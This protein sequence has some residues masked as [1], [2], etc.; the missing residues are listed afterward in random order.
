MGFS[1]IGRKGFGLG[2]GFSFGFRTAALA[3]A[4]KGRLVIHVF[5]VKQYKNTSWM[6]WTLGKNTFTRLCLVLSVSI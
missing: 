6:C 3:A 4:P 2:L 1:S 5:K